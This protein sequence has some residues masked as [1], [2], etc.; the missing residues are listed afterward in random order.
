MAGKQVAGDGLSAS[1]AGMSKNQLYD[2]M[3]QMKQLIDQNQQQ[4]RDILIQNPVLTKALF[5]AQIML[6]MV[7]SPQ[8]IPN[9]QPAAS[10]NPQPSK[11]P[12]QK[13]NIQTASSLPSKIGLQD[14]TIN[15]EP[16]QPATTVSSA[17][18]LPS[19]LQ[20]PSLPSHPLQ[21][22]QQLK[23]NIPNQLT[24]MPLRQASQLPNMPHLSHHASSHLPSHL[25]PP[26]PSSSNQLQQPMQTTS[27]PHLA[28][29]QPPLPTQQR[30]PMPTF[31]HHGHSQI[32]VNVGFQHSGAPQLNHSQPV[33]H[34]GTRPPAG[35]GPSFLLGQPPRPIQAPLQPPYQVGGSQLGTDFNQIVSSN[36]ADRGS[37]WVSGIKQESTSGGQLPGL[38]Q[39]PGLMGPGNQLSQSPSLTPEME[40]ALLQQVMSLTPEQIN[41]LPPEQRNQVLQ[42]QQM[43]RQ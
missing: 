13:S 2:I 39:F 26:M 4:A 3:S 5:Q 17:S 40:K 1:L 7:Q 8:A 23:G 16:S 14:Q 31:P 10:Q 25:Q 43:L 29:L 27:I 18:V 33:Y 37:P 36:Q 11:S 9:V 32:G 12:I 15:Q 35:P 24:Q 6:G 38:P 28:P 19:N 34:S 42:L 22:A 20:P 21:S 41:N 30:P